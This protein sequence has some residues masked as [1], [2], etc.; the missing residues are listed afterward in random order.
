MFSTSCTPS[1]ATTYDNL[2]LYVIDRNAAW[3]MYPNTACA[4]RNEL[5]SQHGITVVQAKSWCQDNAACVSFER[6]PTAG[7]FS[8]STTCTTSV[9]IPYPPWECGKSALCDID[10]YVIDRTR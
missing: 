2:E 1:F 3:T 7:Y 6:Q 8:F 4:G 9:D 10:L 5:A